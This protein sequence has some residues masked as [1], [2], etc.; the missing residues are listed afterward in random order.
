[1]I[2]VQALQKSVTDLIRSCL[3]FSEHYF[4]SLLRFTS[5]E[6]SSINAPKAIIK[7]P[8]QRLM[9][10]PSDGSY[11]SVSPLVTIPRMVRMIPSMLNISPIGILISNPIV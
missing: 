6:V 10:W 5:L 3:L 1:M 9:L 11:I 2:L 7:R 8:D 4:R